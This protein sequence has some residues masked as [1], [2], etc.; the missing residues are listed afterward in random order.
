MQ[1]VLVDHRLDRRDLS[2]QEPLRGGDLADQ[3]SAAVLRPAEVRPVDLLRRQH[4]LLLVLGEP[5]LAAPGT[6][7]ELY[8]TDSLKIRWAARGGCSLGATCR[9]YNRHAAEKP[10]A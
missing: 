8:A 9:T 3:G 10:L 2:M 7:R 1:R 6:P 5:R 4:R